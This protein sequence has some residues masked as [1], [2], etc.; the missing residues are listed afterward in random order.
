MKADATA[1]IED[2]PLITADCE[3]RK[4][5]TIATIW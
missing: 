4:S 1:L 5:R 2:I 3:I